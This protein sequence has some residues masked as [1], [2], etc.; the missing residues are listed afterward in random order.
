[1]NALRNSLI[2]LLAAAVP[3]ALVAQ[4]A[5]SPVFN[6]TA[7]EA[8]LA[9]YVS[10]ALL[11]TALADYVY[12]RPRDIFLSPST[13]RVTAPAATARRVSVDSPCCH[14]ASLTPTH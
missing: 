13:G 8:T 12:R 14:L 4:A 10:A 5:G 2:L 3:A 11:V 1:M 9:A 6:K 7:V